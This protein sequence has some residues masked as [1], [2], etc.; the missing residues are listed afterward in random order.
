MTTEKFKQALKTIVS[1]LQTELKGESID[2]IEFILKKKNEGDLGQ[3]EIL[4]NTKSI[5]G[6]FC[7]WDPIRR[8]VVCS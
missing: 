7:R 4:E 3:K 8:R 1:E 2:S 6:G 5:Q